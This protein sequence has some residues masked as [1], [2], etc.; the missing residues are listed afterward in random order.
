[1]LIQIGS[2][3]PFGGPRSVELLAEAY[4]EARRPDAMSRSTSI[5]A[6]GTRC[7]TR[8]NRAEVRRRRVAW[9]D[10]HVA[11]ARS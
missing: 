8:L 4:R 9:L 5:P 10:G 7:T 1:M 2:E 3:D 11:T 6:R